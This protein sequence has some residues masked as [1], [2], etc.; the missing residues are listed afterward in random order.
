MAAPETFRDQVLEAVRPLGAVMAKPAHGGM[1]LHFGGTSALRV[2]KRRAAVC[3][4]LTSGPARLMV[5]RTMTRRSR[6]IAAR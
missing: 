5:I 3:Q 1:G 6:I 2:D 4:P